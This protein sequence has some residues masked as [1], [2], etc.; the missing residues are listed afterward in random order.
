[1]FSGKAS[2][3]TPPLFVAGVVTA[4]S[5]AHATLFQAISPAD[6]T[7]D[8]SGDLVENGVTYLAVYKPTTPPPAWVKPA[9]ISNT[10][11]YNGDDALGFEVDP[12]TPA[13]GSGTPTDKTQIRISHADDSSSLNFNG[14]T[15][16]ATRY[17]GFALYLPST[18]VQAP[19]KGIVQIAQWWQGGPYGPPLALGISGVSG[20]SATYKL[21]VLND[22]TLGNPSSVPVIL[23]TGSIPFN[24]WN[25]FV[26]ETTMGYNNNGNVQLWE[27][28]TLVV[29]W[30][31]LV[32]YNP[33]TIPYNNPP[34]GTNPPNSAFDVFVGPYRDEQSTQQVEYFDQMRW[35]DSYASALPLPAVQ[36]NQSSGGSWNGA[37][38]WTGGNIPNGDG[39]EA[40]FF[41]SPGV[42]SP[43]IITLDANRTVGQIAFNNIHG[44]TI[45]SGTGGPW[46][47]T[48]NDT[49][50][51][52]GPADPLITVSSGSQSITAAVSL[53]SGLTVSTAGGASLHISGNI[54]GSGEIT[55]TGTGSVVLSGTETYTGS[56][57]IAV[58]ASLTSNGLMPSTASF[59]VS[60]TM[61][62]GGNTGTTILTR[63]MAA[64][65]IS[66][67]LIVS[68]STGSAKSVLVV[69]SN[70][71]TNTGRIDLSSNDLILRNTSI[72]TISSQIAAGYNG[73]NWNGTTG[74]ISSAASANAHLLTALGCAPGDNTFDGISTDAN[75]V[76]VKYTYYGDA[77]LDGK[78]DGSDYS[79]IDNGYLTK[80]TGWYNGDFN[81][82]GTIDGSDYTL[83]DNAFNNQGAQLTAEPACSTAQIA[84]VPEPATI[85]M[86]G[87]AIAALLGRNRRRVVHA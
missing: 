46:T 77:T 78:V 42:T 86:A 8:S 79:R 47:L 26:T 18:Q 43:G 13:A 72:G 6:A 5:W 1:M 41:A 64:L 19:T 53:A 75:D 16:T 27:N 85:G 67:G 37:A 38:N 39:A 23:A 81:Y 7:F 52:Y 25:T 61:I 73:G 4:T 21:Q 3:R 22:M 11:G 32:G 15:M 69:A 58:G 36:W 56:T 29:N 66:G 44:Y 84:A 74:I 82:D 70:G 50:D 80:A 24:S 65:N 63:S 28:G 33:A 62:F 87:C 14:S 68:P 51:P 9:W 34:A 49:S 12:Q 57:T 48:I 2:L 17:L 45:A 20:N 59:N 40:C 83:I 35:A 55:A 54:N 31:G 71:F 60:G 30:S 76:L 10:G